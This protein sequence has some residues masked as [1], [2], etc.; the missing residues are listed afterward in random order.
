M[1][2]LV[3]MFARL[4]AEKPFDIGFETAA[5]TRQIHPLTARIDYRD[6]EIQQFWKLHVVLQ[7]TQCQRR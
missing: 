3:T 2:I 1:N 6:A 4:K 5:T 7:F